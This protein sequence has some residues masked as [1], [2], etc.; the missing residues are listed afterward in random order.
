M[1]DKFGIPR[2][3]NLVAIKSHIRFI[4]PY[5]TPD[6]F[7]GIEHYSHLWILW[8][9]HHNKAQAHFRP[10]VRPPR[11]GGNDKTGVF[12][13]RSM[14]R[15][16]QIGLSVVQLDKVQILDNQVI[17]HIIGAD[18]VDGTPILDIKPYIGF[19][20]SIPTAQSV[21]KP[22]TKSVVF[23]KIAQANFEKLI[24]NQILDNNDQ[25]IIKTLIAQDPRP[26]YRQHETHTPFVMRYK[27]VDVGF[28]DDGQ[29]LV[30]D[31]VKCVL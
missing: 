19:A 28:F 17:L 1:P 9:F 15:P 8:Q 7:V 16:S 26:A 14:Y 18:M 5:N 11:L 2:Q 27:T 22:N 10:Q 12:A 23:D 30:V 31:A 29:R 20:D 6:A 13:T 21:E 3:P 24:E 4:A 25:Q